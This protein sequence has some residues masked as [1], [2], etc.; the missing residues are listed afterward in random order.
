MGSPAGLMNERFKV[1]EMK[2][3]RLITLLAVLFFAASANAQ[4]RSNK[5][6]VAYNPEHQPGIEEISKVKADI[7]DLLKKMVMVWE[8]KPG[9]NE[10]T[11]WAHTKGTLVLDDRIEFRRAN[12]ENIIVYFSDIIDYR[13]ILNYDAINKFDRIYFGNLQVVIPGKG[14]GRKFFDNLILIQN[15]L[16]ENRKSELGLFEPL[17]AQYRA[18]K[19]KPTLSEEQRKYIVQANGFNE[20]KQ[21]ANA[22]EFYKKAIKADPVAYPAAYSNLALLSAQ[23]QRYN[24]A[25]YYMKKYLLLV[26]ETEDARS[27]QDKIYLWEA[28]SGK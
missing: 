17:A 8:L 28:Q 12:R 3:L 14:N 20:E 21:Y 19:E 2:T 15:Q 18:L 9:A 26:P 16:L 13:V 6:P 10:Y 22:I 27:A 5:A 1:D 4:T 7:A 25:I 24:A 23:L 11:Y